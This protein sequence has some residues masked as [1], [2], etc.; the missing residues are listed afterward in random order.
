MAPIVDYVQ[1]FEKASYEK[2]PRTVA[3]EDRMP[4]GVTLVS[5]TVSATN[6]YSGATD[7]TVLSS[8]TATIAGTDASVFVLDGTSGYRYV[9]TFRAV[10]SDGSKFRDDL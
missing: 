6:L 2:L 4:D 9:V 8:T 10:F 3:Y 5:A 7:N 1:I